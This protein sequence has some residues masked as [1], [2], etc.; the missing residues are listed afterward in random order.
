MHLKS[1]SGLER[2]NPSSLQKS[3]QEKSALMET[4]GLFHMKIGMLGSAIME[5][6]IDT[7][8]RK[9]GQDMVTNTVFTHKS[10]YA[11]KSTSLE[12]APPF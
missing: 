9:L 12:L 10:V 3:C 6:A 1:L 2:S 7:T 5:T 8:Y 4:K 11:R